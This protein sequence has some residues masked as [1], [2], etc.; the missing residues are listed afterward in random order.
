MVLCAT[1][2]T[3]TRFEGTLTYSITRLCYNDC[4]KATSSLCQHR[5]NFKSELFVCLICTSM[6]D[7][8][9]KLHR[10]HMILI[11]ENKQQDYAGHGESAVR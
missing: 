2:D 1:G 8:Q 6:Q 11:R 10:M 7:S 9:T 5:I 4:K 3:S